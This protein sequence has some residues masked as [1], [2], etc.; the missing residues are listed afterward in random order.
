[1]V[2]AIFSTVVPGERI[3]IVP[4]LLI[5][6]DRGTPLLAVAQAGRRARLLARL[7]EDRKKDRRENG[8]YGNHHEQL[9]QG[10]PLQQP[11][12]SLSSRS[13]GQKPQVSLRSRPARRW[14]RW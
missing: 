5:H 9:D 6:P 8:N 14:L 2:E 13:A 12:H 3:K 10:E 4:V 1:G 11:S 7:G